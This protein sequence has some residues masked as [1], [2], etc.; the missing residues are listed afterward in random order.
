[1]S[2]VLLIKG[3]QSSGI[4]RQKRT[5]LRRVPIYI[6]RDQKKKQISPTMAL[7][8]YVM[9]ETRYDIAL[10][11]VT[12]PTETR[13]HAKSTSL[14]SSGYNPSD[15]QSPNQGLQII[16]RRSQ[17][18]LTEIYHNSLRVWTESGGRLDSTA[19]GQFP[20]L[21]SRRVRVLSQKK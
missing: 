16:R 17:K 4:D 3:S 10:V 20:E 6:R 2:M 9:S 13:A 11:C 18:R 7:N 5:R 12:S 8:T 21:E 19:T 1:M 14:R 15:R